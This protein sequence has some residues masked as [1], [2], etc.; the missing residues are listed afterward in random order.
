MA[1]FVL[2]SN[3]FEFG[4][5]TKQQQISRTAIGTKFAPPYACIFM[6]NLETKLLEG[7][8]LQPLVCFRYIDDIFSS[9]PIVKSIVRNV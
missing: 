6:N 9:G 7:Q 8:Q 4:N 2:K 3:N 1:V 5:N